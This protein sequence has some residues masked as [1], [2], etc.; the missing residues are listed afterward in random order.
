MLMDID[1]YMNGY[2]NGYWRVLMDM[3]GYMHGYVNGY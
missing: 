1:V 3:N 2:V